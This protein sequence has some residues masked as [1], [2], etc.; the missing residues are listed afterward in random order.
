M[1]LFTKSGWTNQMV[2]EPNVGAR[3]ATGFQS[4]AEAEHWIEI[5]KRHEFRVGP[6][7]RLKGPY[8]NPHINGAPTAAW[9]FG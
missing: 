5:Q 6:A 1:N 4:M 9:S 3:T 7:P 8:T 2:D